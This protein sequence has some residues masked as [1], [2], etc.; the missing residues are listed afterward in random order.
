MGISIEA[1]RDVETGDVF[2]GTKIVVE[3][4]EDA[5][6][7]LGDVAGGEILK[8]IRSELPSDEAIAATEAYDYLREQAEEP[9][10]DQDAIEK[11]VDILK[12]LAPY[13]LDALA[14][15]MPWLAQ[16]L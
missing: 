7:A 5:Q 3:D 4:L 16:I 10:E 15:A 2:E 12:E 9:G 8:R 6:V 13:A 14:G 11:A 1:G